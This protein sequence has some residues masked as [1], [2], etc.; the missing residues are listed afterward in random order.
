MIMKRALI[1]IIFAAMSAVCFA[2]STLHFTY[3]SAG[4]RTERTI[5]INSSAPQMSTSSDNSLYKD[6]SIRISN[7]QQ[8]VLTVEILGLNDAAQVAIYDSSGKQFIAV[9]INSSISNVDI[10]AVPHGIY[11]LKIH[12]NNKVN[13]WKLIKK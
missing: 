9:E 8:D 1:S 11:V 4:N 13:T 5:V 7:H 12:A 3:D 6:E 10:S 2:Q